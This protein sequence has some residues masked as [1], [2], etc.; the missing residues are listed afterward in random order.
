MLVAIDSSKR[1]TSSSSKTLHTCTAISGRSPEELSD[2]SADAC[3]FASTK[4]C[5]IAAMT[6]VSSLS[7]SH[8]A[9]GK[10][11][12]SGEISK[13][14]LKVLVLLR[15]R[16]IAASLNHLVLQISTNSAM[17][18]ATRFV[19]SS[20]IKFYRAIISKW[21]AVGNINFYVK[22]MRSGFPKCTH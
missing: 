10:Y 20:W 5:R 13:R 11:W 15:I 22:N 4:S 2:R 9:S 14:S 16:W 21:L 12:E 7:S 6:L 17:S 3:R 19:D 18:S 1:R 8:F